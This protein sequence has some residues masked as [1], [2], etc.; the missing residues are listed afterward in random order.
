MSLV[1]L[2][3]YNKNFLAFLAHSLSMVC[4]AAFATLCSIDRAVSRDIVGEDASATSPGQ[5]PSVTFTKTDYI[6]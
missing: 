3:Y 5:R 6:Y 4:F 1:C 2:D